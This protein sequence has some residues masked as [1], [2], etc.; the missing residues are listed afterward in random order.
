MIS[1]AGKRILL[2]ITKAWRPSA[3]GLGTSK[4]FASVSTSATCEGFTE[5]KV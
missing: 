1:G 4:V 3:E 2:W 5:A